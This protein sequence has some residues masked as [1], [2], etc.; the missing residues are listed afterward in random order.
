MEVIHAGRTT[1]RKLIIELRKLPPD[2]KVYADD[3][4]GWAAEYIHLVYDKHDK[5]LC[6]LGRDEDE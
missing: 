4:N 5:T 3:G 6:I 2:T 1:I